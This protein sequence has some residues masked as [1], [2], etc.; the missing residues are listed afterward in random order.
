MTGKTDNWMSRI[1]EKG[2]I[3]NRIFFEGDHIQFAGI[4]EPRRRGR[5]G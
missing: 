5:N 1:K 3:K 2:R 4:M